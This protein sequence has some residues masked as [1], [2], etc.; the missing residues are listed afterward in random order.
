MYIYCNNT[1]YKNSTLILWGHQVLQFVCSLFFLFKRICGNRMRPVPICIINLFRLVMMQ[2]WCD[3]ILNQGQK[4]FIVAF[5]P[6]PITQLSNAPF[7]F[8]VLANKQASYQQSLCY[9]PE[10]GIFDFT[11]FSFH[12]RLRIFEQFLLTLSPRCFAAES[13]F[14]FLPLNIFKSHFKAFLVWSNSEK[15]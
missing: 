8:N 11:E 5:L 15:N 4:F 2:G 14:F 9:F 3:C 12:W 13:P 6:Y 7:R 10:F 1:R